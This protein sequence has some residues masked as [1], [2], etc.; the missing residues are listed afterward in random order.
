M[1][2]VLGVL[3]SVGYPNPDRRSFSARMDIWQNR[4]REHR[5][6]HNRLDRPDS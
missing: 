4:E 6:Y 2:G 5:I 1:M 3:N